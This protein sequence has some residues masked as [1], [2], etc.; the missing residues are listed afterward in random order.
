MFE[1]PHQLKLNLE[2]EL[3][4]RGAAALARDAAALS[5]RYRQSG[6]GPAEPVAYA[7]TRMPATFAATAAAL[8]A[9]AAGLSGPG[10]RTLLDAGAGTGAALWAAAAIW[11]EIEGATLIERSLPM[12]ELGRRLAAGAGGAV[13]TARWL[14][15]DLAGPWEVAP[16]DL[17]TAAYALGELTEGAR[18]ALVTR[19]WA[20]AQVAL[21]IV[22]PG[23]PRGW[24]V[25]RAAREQ[26]RAEGARIIAPCP[27]ESHCPMPDDDWCHFAQRLARTRG[28]RA[29]KG[30]ALGYE[31]EKYS[32]V[33]VARHG[34]DP[35]GA[36]V[37]RRPVVRPGRIE[38]TLCARDGLRQPVVTKA[39]REAWRLARDLGWGSAVPPDTLE[40]QRDGPRDRE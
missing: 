12:V 27:H 3:R 33:A 26:L 15:A 23:T 31:D 7:I 25:I 38:L 32:Y 13:A 17:V 6:G 10:P 21:V 5:S 40:G 28:H 34:G 11:P 2:R 24:A 18:A 20:Q 19:L 37:L 14:T 22:E 39:D 36:R 8:A 30:A 16:H 35:A 4:G 9:L 1:L 29:A